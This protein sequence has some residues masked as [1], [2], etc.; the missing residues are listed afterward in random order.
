LKAVFICAVV[1]VGLLVLARL[2]GKIPADCDD[3][4]EQ[5]ASYELGNYAEL[6]DRTPMV[7]RSR[8]ICKRASVNRDEGACLDKAKTKLAAA[9]CVP[10]LF[11]EIEVADCK[12]AACI[13][14]RLKQFADQMCACGPGNKPCADK[15]NEQMTTWGQQLSSARS[16]ELLGRMS[17][18]DTEAMRGI[19]SRY[20][21][22]MVKSL[23]MQ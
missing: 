9:R 10:R 18:Q 14:L 1:V 15:V 8:A 22:C 2:V 21:E 5:L 19:M 11:P 4:A 16:G 3:V 13:V 23:T 6:E 17:E 12:D 20:G 7:E